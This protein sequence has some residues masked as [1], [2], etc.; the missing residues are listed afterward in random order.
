MGD[1][2]LP[3]IQCAIHFFSPFTVQ[4]TFYFNG[5]QVLYSFFQTC[6]LLGDIPKLHTV[7]RIQF[8]LEMYPR[9]KYILIF[10][11][12]FTFEMTEWM[13]RETK[14]KED[15]SFSQRE[16]S[17]Q[18]V[19]CSVNINRFHFT[20]PAHAPYFHPIALFY[21]NTQLRQ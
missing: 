16:R 3:C 17:K 13:K 21:P 11:L 15:V 10:L 4:D 8:E 12:N 5:G 14:A 6:L 7:K 2:T 9:L 1:G 20:V 19:H 18:R